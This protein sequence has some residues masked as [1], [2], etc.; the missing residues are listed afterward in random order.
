MQQTVGVRIDFFQICAG[1][2]VE[3][4]FLQGEV[5][6]TDDR[7]HRRAQFMAHFGEKVVFGGACRIRGMQSVLRDGVVF[8]TFFFRSCRIAQTALLFFNKPFKFFGR[9]RL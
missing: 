1:V 9:N 4:L 3:I 7:V 2:G 5:A 8:N 6:K